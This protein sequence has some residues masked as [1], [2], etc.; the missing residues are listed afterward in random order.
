L[1]V[2]KLKTQR[3]ISKDYKAVEP[4]LSLYP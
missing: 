2:K 3:C 1:A 4:S